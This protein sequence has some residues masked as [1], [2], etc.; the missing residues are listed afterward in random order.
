MY[1]PYGKRKEEKTNKT[2]L[3]TTVQK[4]EPVDDPIREV[5]LSLV[6]LVRVHHE[7]TG[8]FVVVVFVFCHFAKDKNLLFISSKKDNNS[9]RSR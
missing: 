1:H 2:C 8:N 4:N 5:T 9:L 6:D 7:N 3:F